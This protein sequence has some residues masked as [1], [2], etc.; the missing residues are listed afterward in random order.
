MKIHHLR[1]ASLVIEADA[2]VILVDPILGSAGKGI[3]F[4]FVRFKPRRNPMVGLPEICKPILEKVTHCLITHNH[5]D[6][7]DRAAI[8]YLKENNIPITCSSIEEKIYKRKGLNV[9]QTLD[10]WEKVDFWGGTIEGIPALHGYG[11]VAKIMGP[12]MG[13][14]IELPN[15]P[16]IYI[17]SDT[18]YTNDV[19]KVLNTYN[20][21]LS[22]AACGSAQFDILKPLLMTMEDIVKFVKNAPNKVLAN[23]MEAINHCPT[24][25]AMLKA[26]LTQRRLIDKVFIPEDGEIIEL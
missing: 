24:T 2:R 7:L 16:S 13:F 10:Y 1:N 3:P 18:I 15:Q 21:S 6:H 8:Q 11:F 9:V 22:V 19:D 20:P 23:H 5:P 4:T 17:S 14:Y 12:V 26:E 25:R